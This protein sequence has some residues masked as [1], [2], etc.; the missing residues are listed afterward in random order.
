MRPS[1]DGLNDL[2]APAVTEF[3]RDGPIEVTLIRIGVELSK[4]ALAPAAI[5]MDRLIT[6]EAH[7]FPELALT[8]HENAVMSGS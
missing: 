7:Q 3:N 2:L 5:A 6:L 8:Y 4:R 1:S